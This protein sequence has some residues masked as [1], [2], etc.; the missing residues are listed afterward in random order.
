[1]KK[2]ILSSL[3]GF[4]LSSYVIAGGNIEVIETPAT[5]ISIPTSYNGFYIGMGYGRTSHEHDLYSV[6]LGTT[7]KAYDENFNSVMIQA[8][9]QINAYIALEGR[10]WFGFD[11]DF[12]VNQ[13]TPVT[14]SIDTWAIYVKPMYPISEKFNLY[15]LLGYAGVQH[16]VN[17]NPPVPNTVLGDNYNGFSWGLGASYS[18][19]DNIS[20]FADYVDI[21]DDDKSWIHPIGGWEKVSDEKIDMWSI[22]ISYKF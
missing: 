20:I 9:Y 12:I 1:M 4:G 2:I 8:G 13:R 7:N 18:I 19:T 16:N 10:Y 17:G 5:N 22:G 6:D 14:S 11:N 21:Y 15:A 3:I